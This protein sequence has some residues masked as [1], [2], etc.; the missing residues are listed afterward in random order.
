MMRVSIPLDCDFDYIEC[1]NMYYDYQPYVKDYTPFEDILKTTF[2]YAIYDKQKLSLCVYFYCDEYGKLW[3]NG[4]GIR[5][6]HLFNK[7]S[8][9]TVLTWFNCDIW[10]ES[11]QK[12]AIYGLL[13]CGFKKYKDGIYVFRQKNSTTEQK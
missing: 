5:K 9:K 12:P 2:F 1:E 13:S 3:V 7:R 10:A 8:F 6:N 11:Y 4:Y